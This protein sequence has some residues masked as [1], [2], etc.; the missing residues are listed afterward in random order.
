[1]FLL[2]KIY[3]YIMIVFYFKRIKKV[4]Q[5]SVF[6]LT[7]CTNSFFLLCFC[8]A[9]DERSSLPLGILC[10]QRLCLG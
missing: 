7:V 1:M 10:T 5:C 9:P 3:L 2:F 8:A 4:F 6:V